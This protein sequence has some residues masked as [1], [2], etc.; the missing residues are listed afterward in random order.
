MDAMAIIGFFKE[1]FREEGELTPKETYHQVL[2]IFNQLADEAMKIELME[3]L[4]KSENF[5]S[6]ASMTERMLSRLAKIDITVSVEPNPDILP[7]KK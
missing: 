1:H 3:N 6:M 4:F 7:I 2:F 5:L